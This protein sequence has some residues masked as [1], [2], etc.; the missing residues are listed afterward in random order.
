MGEWKLKLAK[1]E[2]MLMSCAG[3]QTVGSRVQASNYFF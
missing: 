3:V 1:R 2:D